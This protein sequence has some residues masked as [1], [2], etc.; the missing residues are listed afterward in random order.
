M[1]SCPKELKPFD[2]AHQRKIT[3]FDTL[4]FGWWGNYGLTAV[5]VAVEHCL[6]K[7]PKSKYLEEPMTA[8]IFENYGL[9][10]KEIE[11]KEI[12]KAILAEQQ[13][14]MQA[15]MKNLPKTEMK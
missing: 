10:Q 12:K 9:T 5:S 13:W 15:K 1:D 14:Q 11:E 8:K 3:E 4:M 2:I 6:S 7:H